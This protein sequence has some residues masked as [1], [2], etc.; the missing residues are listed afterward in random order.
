MPG[1]VTSHRAC[2]FFLV[3]VYING[4]SAWYIQYSRTGE[5]P[6]AAPL[7]LQQ[8]YRHDASFCFQLAEVPTQWA[9]WT[10]EKVRVA[11]P[12]KESTSRCPQEQ[13]LCG[14]IYAD[15]SPTNTFY[16]PMILFVPKF[17]VTWPWVHESM[18][19]G[20][21]ALTQCGSADTSRTDSYLN[22]CGAC[23]FRKL[24]VGWHIWSSKFL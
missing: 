22:V 24:V 5:I 14:K 13:K 9:S 20:R 3:W 19:T 21:K 6:S 11:W 23:V 16:I 7:M 15:A 10:Q 18:S 17:V 1:M 8:K 2:R 12:D 4:Q